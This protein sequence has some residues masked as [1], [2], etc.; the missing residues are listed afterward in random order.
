MDNSRRPIPL[1]T[2]PLPMK[3]RLKELQEAK[4]KIRVKPPPTL[5]KFPR[6]PF[7]TNPTKPEEPPP[8]PKPKPKPPEVRQ[9]SEPEEKAGEI[10]VSK[11]PKV[12]GI[13]DLRPSAAF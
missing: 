10:P 7:H 6:G 11:R 8:K 13:V 1:P 12:D 5:P 2:A 9:R 4:A 3:Q